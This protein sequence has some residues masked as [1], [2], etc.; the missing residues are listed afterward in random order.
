MKYL[1]LILSLI[2]LS[3]FSKDCK[4]TADKG[5]INLEWTAYKTPAKAGV[6]GR[7]KELGVEKDL[8]A[9]SLK[10]LL[11][12]IEFNIDTASTRTK[13]TA[14]DANI[15]KHFFQ[16]VAGGLMIKGKTSKY[17]NKVLTV[18]LTMNEKNL[19]LPLKVERSDKKIV[20]TGVLDLFDLNLGKALSSINK[21][22]Y[23]L[24]QGKTWNDVAI[25]LTIYLDNKCD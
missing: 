22:C 3:T 4:W 24:H 2:S 5:N 17:E 13:N 6:E 16:Q 23:K 9:D 7:F 8:S 21:A 1:L 25:K 10:G 12:G 15:V 11:E 14:R 19:A 18:D 20:A